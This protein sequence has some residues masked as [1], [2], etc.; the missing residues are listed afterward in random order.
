MMRRDN[1]AMT[2]WRVSRALL[3]LLLVAVAASCSERPAGT[4]VLLITLDTTRADRL[5]CYGYGAARTPRLDGLAL[6]GALFD[7]AFSPVPMTLPAHASLMTGLLPPEHGLHING[8]GRLAEPVETLAERLKARG[9]ATGAFIG[10]YVL[11][12]KFGLAQGFDAYDD[13]L[14]Q[15][16]YSDIDLYRYRKGETV[17]SSALQW[18]AKQRRPFFCW[19][20]LFDPHIPYDTHPELFGDTY[21]SRPYDA[22]IAYV[23]LQVGRILDALRERHLDDTTLVIAAGDHGEGLGDHGERTHGYMIYNSTMRVPLLASLPGRIAPGRRIAHRVSLID[24]CPTILDLLGCDPAGGAAARSLRPLLEGGAAEA[25]PIYGES[26]LGLRSHG[27]APLYSLLSD[28]WKFIETKAPELFDFESDPGEGTNRVDHEAAVRE[29]MA[30]RLSTFRQGLVRSDAQAVRLS[31]DE[32]TALRSLGYAAGRKQTEGAGR[33][34]VKEM[35]PLFNRV[36]DAKALRESGRPLEAATVLREIVSA[37]PDQVDWTAALALSLDQAGEAAEA[38][39]LYRQVLSADPAHAQATHDLGACLARQGR[40][41]EAVVVLRK[42]VELD[43]L[44]P[45]ALA[46]LGAVLAGMGETAEARVCFDGALRLK[47][48]YV[49]AHVNL[50]LL[51]GGEGRREDA[52]R[53]WREVLRLQPNHAQAAA[54]VERLSSP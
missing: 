24:L 36:L 53:H 30:A 14:R 21:A 43:P 51:D 32:V 15:G 42:A 54:M 17:A 20:H 38:E 4:N 31:Q 1:Q 25:E 34:D 13:D 33:R 48:D 45:S 37:A 52:L 26:E 5:G 44:S 9:Y 22:E 49:P 27:W 10:A 6:G 8:E 12:K 29:D 18:L 2:M 39:K 16:G 28:R 50:G 19:V 11:D 35:M 3:S 23:D 41:E 46:N 47:P 40:K 7:Q